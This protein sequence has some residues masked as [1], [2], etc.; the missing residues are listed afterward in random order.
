MRKTVIGCIDTCDEQTR[1][2]FAWRCGQVTRMPAAQ[3]QLFADHAA[4]LGTG[5]S[6][7]QPAVVQCCGGGASS[8][9]PEPKGDEMEEYVTMRD[10]GTEVG[11]SSHQV[12]R[13]L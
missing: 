1:P 2:L 8:R 7:R 13:R 11:L 4:G 3:D 9:G 5:P 6:R 12:G 10:I